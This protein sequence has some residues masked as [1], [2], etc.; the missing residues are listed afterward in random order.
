M[1]A[2]ASCEHFAAKRLVF[3]DRLLEQDINLQTQLE[4]VHKS[5]RVAQPQNWL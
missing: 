2:L 5:L 4:A 3:P 1:G